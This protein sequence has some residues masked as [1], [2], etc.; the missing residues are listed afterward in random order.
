M[1]AIE[2]VGVAANGQRVVMH[3]FALRD[4]DN[5]NHLDAC[6]GPETTGLQLVRAQ[7]NSHTFYAP[8]NVPGRAITVP[9]Q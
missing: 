3:P 1:L 7:V 2:I 6:M 9:I 4:D 5:D 8:Q